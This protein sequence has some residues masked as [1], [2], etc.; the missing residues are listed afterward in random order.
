MLGIALADLDQFARQVR[1]HVTLHATYGV[2]AQRHPEPDWSC[3]LT[4]ST[5][6]GPG[7]Y[8]G[9]GASAEEAISDVLRQI[10]AAIEAQIPPEEEAP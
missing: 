1:G 9:T 5:P 7:A 2:E 6:D 3:Q 8:Y 10:Y 4:F